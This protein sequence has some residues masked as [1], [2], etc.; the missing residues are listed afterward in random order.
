MGR[1]P[2]YQNSRSLVELQIS[3]RQGAKITPSMRY[4]SAVSLRPGC[5]KTK[6]ARPPA[7]A[8]PPSVTSVLSEASVIPSFDGRGFVLDGRKARTQIGCC[9]NALRRAVKA[10]FRA[11]HGKELNENPMRF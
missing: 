7:K 11:M 9:A 2:N 4:P 5:P 1:S 8:E 10:A 6:F 3:L